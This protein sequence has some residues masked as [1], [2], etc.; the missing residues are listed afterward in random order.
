MPSHI[1]QASALFAEI[2]FEMENELMIVLQVIAELSEQLAHNQK[3]TKAIQSQAGSLKDQAIEATSG[4][5]L[6]RVNADISKE[7][8]ESELERQNAQIIIENQMLL[9]EN[10]QLS[11]LLKDY[12]NTM[13]TIMSKFRNHALAAQQHELTLTRHYETLLSSR[14]SNGSSP[15][16]LLNSN[17]I[18]SL[19]RLAS[20]LRGLL[21]TMAGENP[22]SYENLDPDYDGSGL[23]V[24][25]LQELSGL[26]EFLSLKVQ[27]YEGEGREDWALEREC[28]ISRL[29]KEND[30]LRRMLGIDE[31]TMAEQGVSLDLDR[32][33]SS[34]YSTLL[35]SA[36]RRLNDPYGGRQPYWEGNG[37]AGSLQRPMD[38]QPGMR[39]GPQAR[40]PGIFGAAQQQ[41]PGFI[42]GV[43]RGVSN[44]L[45]GN[46]G[47]SPWGNQPSNQNVLLDSNR[48]WHLQPGIPSLDMTR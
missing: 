24:I 18:K 8:F 31:G 21:K 42:G 12:E 23:G 45:T 22:D 9:Y 30:E 37:P 15:D 32:I 19:Q 33:E 17:M 46:P 6:R 7:T 5:A 1:L 25:D 48:P 38:L 14:E 20:H 47:P 28:E 29:E 35:T 34:R 27:G 41:R 13:E 40:R 36:S 39:A 26:L 16:T 2:S 3:L 43:G 11:L 4:F 10:K 44:A